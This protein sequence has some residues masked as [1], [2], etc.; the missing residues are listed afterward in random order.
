MACGFL[1]APGAM[2]YF[3]EMELQAL[4]NPQGIVRRALL[5]QIPVPWPAWCCTNGDFFYD[6]LT[7]SHAL[8][9]AGI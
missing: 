9:H 7:L 5:R 3:S 6:I 8:R 2:G 1:W 4:I